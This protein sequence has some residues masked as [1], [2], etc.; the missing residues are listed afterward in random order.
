MA[1]VRYS[2]LASSDLYENSEFIARDKPEAAYRWVEKIESACRT[3]ATNPEMGQRRI[4]K[5][6]G[7]CRS[8]SCGSYVIFFR[9]LDDG[10]E[11]V[12]IVRGERDLDNV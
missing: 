6:H 7:P 8:F 3:L 4:S 10:V 1:R 2:Q 5:N 12:R 11:I 9:A